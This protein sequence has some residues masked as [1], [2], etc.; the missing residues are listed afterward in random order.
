MPNY[1]DPAVV[2]VALDVVFHD[3]LADAALHALPRK[4]HPEFGTPQRAEDN[5][6]EIEVTPDGKQTV[7]TR[8][9]FVGWRFETPN[10]KCVTQ[11]AR[12]QFALSY[13]RQHAPFGHY[14]GW[15]AVFEKYT[16][17]WSLVREDY[18]S[19]R[20]R[21]VGLR[22]INR[23]VVPNDTA[24]ENWLKVGMRAPDT[25]RN[26]FA[27]Q[28]RQTWEQIRDYEELAATINLAKV[29]PDA[30]MREH[31]RQAFVL[32]IDLFNLLPEKAP[33]FGEL[34]EWFRRAHEAEN[35]VFEACI[36]D[37]LRAHFNSVTEHAIR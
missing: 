25:L 26:V 37:D 8:R 33:R 35:L 31:G 27:L 1:R 10:P 18:Q 11:V 7:T 23:V 16:K 17:L 34:K 36:T 21:R 29:E 24:L 22:Y 19:L 4:L 15:P 13:V 9:A 12:S 32:D 6:L 5:E 30:A 2:E 28:L 3:G 20:P 14:I